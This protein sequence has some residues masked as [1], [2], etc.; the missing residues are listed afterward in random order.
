MIMILTPQFCTTLAKGRPYFIISSTR[1]VVASI[2]LICFMVY[3]SYKESL[4][5]TK[6]Q[7]ECMLALTISN[8][9]HLFLPSLPPLNLGGLRVDVNIVCGLGLSFVYNLCTTPHVTY[10]SKF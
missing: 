4:V 5:K 6:I 10:D 9:S 7:F 1:V 8:S 2:A 3:F